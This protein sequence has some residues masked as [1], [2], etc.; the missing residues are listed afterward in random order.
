MPRAKDEAT[1]EVAGA[2]AAFHRALLAGDVK[3]LE[4]AAHEAFVWTHR[5]GERMTR[6]QLVDAL[7]SGRLRYTKLD[8]TDVNVAVHGATAVVRGRWQAL[9]SAFP[10][11]PSGGDRDPLAAVYTLTLADEGEGWKAVAL[12]SNRPDDR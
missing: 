1:R 4:A 10:G 6:P 11:G 2:D 3:A 12:H 5:T 9:R 7:T 8:T